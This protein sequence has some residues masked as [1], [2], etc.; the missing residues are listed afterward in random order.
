MWWYNFLY[1]VEAKISWV[2]RICEIVKLEV[3]KHTPDENDFQINEQKWILRSHDMFSKEKN[4]CVY[5][6][7]WIL[8]LYFMCTFGSTLLIRSPILVKLGFS[9]PWILQPWNSNNH[10]FCYLHGVFLVPNRV[11]LEL[12]FL[13][14]MS[15]E[16]FWFQECWATV[17][18]LS[19]LLL[20]HCNGLEDGAVLRVTSGGEFVLASIQG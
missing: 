12:Q 19:L 3:P 4:W 20:A 15:S 13:I 11:Q 17:S 5:K 18:L 14:L 8:R 10:L 16:D 2:L 1:Y 9:S 7:R 6:T